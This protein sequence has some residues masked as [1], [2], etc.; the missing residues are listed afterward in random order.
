[1]MSRLRDGFLSLCDEISARCRRVSLPRRR[2]RPKV[3]KGNMRNILVVKP[4][5]SAFCEAIFILRDDYF[6]DG[7]ISR[8]ELLRQ[9]QE[10]A[11]DFAGAYRYAPD[12]LLT[13]I[14]VAA[15]LCA[16]LT[17]V[18]FIIW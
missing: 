5:S 11:E 15:A 13:A 8:Q 17:A 2:V 18:A 1:M 12:S 16:I 4:Q 10:E 3:L 6:N 7:G 14:L 9:A